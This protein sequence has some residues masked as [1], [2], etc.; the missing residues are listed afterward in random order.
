MC[1]LIEQKTD[2]ENSPEAIVP[3]KFEGNFEFKDVS[4]RYGNKNRY[5]LRKL[6][7]EINQGQMVALVSKTGEGKTTLIR[8][9]CRMYDVEEGGIFLDERE[10]KTIDLS[11]YRKLFAVVQQDVDIF[12]TSII[13]NIKY[14]Y[15]RSTEE[16]VRESLKASHLEKVIN[17]ENRFP[18]GLKTQVGE[19]GVRLS[20][21]ERQR[22]GIAR[23]YLSLLNG[24]KVLVL[25]EATSA[26]DS[27][28]E[29]EIM[30]E[31]YNV[32]EDKTLIIIAHRLSTTERCQRVYTIENKKIK[33]VR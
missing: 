26:L 22:V 29:S 8:L 4:F 20:G 21:G 24:V 23:A 1:E 13:N 33:M 28:T 16:Q 5:I 6:N 30:D 12:D 10:I 18:D 19:R 3:K 2:V 32:S 31:I 14:A 9:L 11:W 27:E 7:L 25:D 15:P 17:D